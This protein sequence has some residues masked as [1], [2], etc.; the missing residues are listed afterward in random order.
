MRLLNDKG[1]IL[2]TDA[3][4]AYRLP[5]RRVTHTAVVHCKKNINGK[6]VNPHY[7]KSVNVV[8][9]GRKHW[10][11]GGTQYIHGLWRMLRKAI[12]GSH[13]STNAMEQA[14][15]YA[16]WKYWNMGGDLLVALAETLG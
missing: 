4:R 11:R 3:A 6:W 10:V 7:T 15:R 9:D 16:Q 2:H 12:Y 5:L 8:C 13:G 1:V 14:I